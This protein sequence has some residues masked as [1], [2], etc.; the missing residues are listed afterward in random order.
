MANYNSILKSKKYLQKTVNCRH[1]LD[2]RMDILKMVFPGISDYEG[3]DLPSWEE[4]SAP[5]S[6]LTNGKM[7]LISQIGAIVGKSEGVFIHPTAK[8]GESVQIDGPSF[9]GE[10]AVIRHGAYLRKG[11]WI[12][13]GA[14]VGHCTEVK[15]SVLLPGSNAAHFNYVGDSILGFGSNL[16]AGV[17]LSNVRNDRRGIF[18]T[19]EDGSRIDTGLKKMGALIGDGSQIGCNTVTNPGVIILPSNLINPNLTV[20][21]WN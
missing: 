6:V 18:V 1:S 15:N 8:I 7:G 4:N 21:G 5:W 13:S 20:S 16:G 19:L 9:I 12:C 17:K 2:I 10:N 3:E 11:S 14:L